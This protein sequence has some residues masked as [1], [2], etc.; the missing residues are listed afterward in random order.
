[1]QLNVKR[2]Q[3]D[4]Y[5]EVVTG[6]VQVS[7]S[8]YCSQ[9][10]FNK[11]RQQSFSASS[12]STSVWNIIRSN[13][14]RRSSHSELLDE[15]L[16]ATGCNLWDFSHGTT[17]SCSSLLL[18]VSLLTLALNPKYYQLGTLTSHPPLSASL[19]FGHIRSAV[20]LATMLPLSFCCMDCTLS[21][22][23]INFNYRV[24]HLTMWW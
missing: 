11:T 12:D 17:N 19:Y 7:T 1:M 22:L 9:N 20:S 23:C 15:E 16:Q 24:L 2:T 10:C 8:H 3:V 4:F 18:S 21:L 6:I 5:C 14:T 13:G